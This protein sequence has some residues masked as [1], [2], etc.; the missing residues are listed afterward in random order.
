M[1]TLVC[2]TR[3][4]LSHSG[5]ET[6]SEQNARINELHSLFIDTGFILLETIIPE[7]E[8][9][10]PHSFW[11]GQVLLS[12]GIFLSQ[13]ELNERIAT[14]FRKTGSRLLELQTYITGCDLLRGRVEFAPLGTFLARI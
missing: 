5:D 9:F 6:T 1:A 11:I 14:T 12:A 8:S 13:E 2:G 4:L 10:E 7:R 3:C